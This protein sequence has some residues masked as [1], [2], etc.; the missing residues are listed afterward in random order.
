MTNISAIELGRSRNHVLRLKVYH[1]VLKRPY[2]LLLA[3]GIL[4]AHTGAIGC[5]VLTS[6]SVYIVSQFQSPH[7]HEALGHGKVHAGLVVDFS[8]SGYDSQLFG[9]PIPQ[10]LA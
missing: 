6:V 4:W 1:L 10:S 3:Y 9:F 5:I 2:K 7:E 8:A